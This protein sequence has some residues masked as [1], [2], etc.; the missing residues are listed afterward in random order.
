MRERSPGLSGVFTP[1]S[2]GSNAPRAEKPLLV[3]DAVELLQCG[4]W[5][6]ETSAAGAPSRS[7]GRLASQRRLGRRQPRDRDAERRARD[8]VEPDAL[9]ECDAGGIAAML[10][11]DA[12]LDVRPR[13]PAALGGERHQL[14]DALSTAVSARFDFRPYV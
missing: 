12:E 7:G 10:A 4:A 8:I 3:A 9:A 6:L 5:S 13:R 1:K 11:A 2:G 14:A